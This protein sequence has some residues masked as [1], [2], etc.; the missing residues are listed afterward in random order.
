MS[1]R[2]IQICEIHG[3][4]EFGIYKS[5][6]KIR[7]RCLKCQTAATQKRRD[8]VKLK[9]IAYK[10]SKCQCCGYDKYPGALEF[11]HINPEEKDFA[12]S[13]KGYTRSWKSVKDELD[14]CVM[15]C[16]NCHKEIHANV[17]PCPTEII[18]DED[19]ANH[20]Y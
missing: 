13:A 16:S 12:I 11:H 6:S 9:A 17:I 2:I 20:I 19:S 10:G 15:V 1:E 3:E 8:L 4:T 7:Y 14:K 18:R 5:G